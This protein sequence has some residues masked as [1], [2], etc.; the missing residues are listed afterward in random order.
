MF[1]T[2]TKPNNKQHQD[3]FLPNPTVFRLGWPFGA[4]SKRTCQPTLIPV[5]SC[6]LSFNDATVVLESIIPRKAS[7][8]AAVFCPLKQGGRC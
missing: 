1:F 7:S 2:S 3:V 8:P 4:P 5:V 6:N